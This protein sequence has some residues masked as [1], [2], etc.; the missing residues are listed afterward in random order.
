MT[1]N[2]C[3]IKDVKYRSELSKKEH[4]FEIMMEDRNVLLKTKKIDEKEEW[5]NCI[6]KN[7]DC[8]LNKNFVFSCETFGDDIFGIFI[9]IFFYFFLFF[10]IYL[11]YLFI[12]FYFIFIFYLFIIL[13]I[14]LFFIYLFL[15]YFI[16]ILFLF[17]FKFYLL[18]Y[19]YFV[20]LFFS[21]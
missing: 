3:E 18:F 15:F 8:E 16:F 12:L 6:K 5:F 21:K 17:Y 10:F 4:F 7:L 9:F 14:I 2:V 1:L 19:F 11:F 13:F 20:F